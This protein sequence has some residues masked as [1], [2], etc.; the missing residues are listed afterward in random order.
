MLFDLQLFLENKIETKYLVIAMVISFII[1]V[2][3]AKS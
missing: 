3:L 2:L 1:G